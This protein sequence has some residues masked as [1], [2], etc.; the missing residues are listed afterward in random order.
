[1]RK[2]CAD[3]SSPRTSSF[4][5]NGRSR[6]TVFLVC[7]QVAFSNIVNGARRGDRERSLRLTPTPVRRHQNPGAVHKAPRSFGGSPAFGGAGA[8]RQK[9]TYRRQRAIKIRSASSPDRS[10]RPT[11]HRPKSAARTTI[12]RRGPDGKACGS[13]DEF[14]YGPIAGGA[15]RVNSGNVFTI[16]STTSIRI[17]VLRWRPSQTWG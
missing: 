16:A 17:A 5:G 15:S 11:A 7:E 9:G 12:A 6:A 14:V 2:P 4:R 13:E 10:R 1:M 3:I 8:A